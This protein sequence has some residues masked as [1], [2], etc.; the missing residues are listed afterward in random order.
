MFGVSCDGQVV[1]LLHHEPK[2]QGSIPHEGNGS[3]LFSD[4][5]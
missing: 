3:Q 5:P 2:N 4:D 1:A